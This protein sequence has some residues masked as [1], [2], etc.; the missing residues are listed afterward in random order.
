MILDS[1]ITHTDKNNQVIDHNYTFELIT[2]LLAVLYGKTFHYHGIIESHGTHYIP[3]LS[4]LQQLRNTRFPFNSNN[5]R[6]DFGINLNFN[7][8]HKFSPL[9]KGHITD[10]KF[11]N[12]FYTACKFYL[13]AIN[14]AEKEPDLAYL[15]LITALEIASNIYITKEMSEELFTENEISRLE[16]IKSIPDD[17]EHLYKYFKNKFSHIKRKFVRTVLDNIDDK[18]WAHTESI[19]TLGAF[20]QDTF[21]DAIKA[22]YDFRSKYVH[23]GQ[24]S[25]FR[26]LKS[27]GYCYEVPIRTNK[28]KS[29]SIEKTLNRAPTFFGLERITR[30]VLLQIAARHNAFTNP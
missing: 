29:N 2:S 20:S 7:E 4:G 28:Y 19:N 23:V 21:E 15:H 16:K 26:I 14:T 11:I 1:E 12:I 3:D 17:G 6:H 22:A 30:Y 25:E 10:T 9:L 18:F 24:A 8:L 5:C 13:K 27:H